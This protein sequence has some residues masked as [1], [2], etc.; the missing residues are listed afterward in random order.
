M[1]GERLGQYRIE[2]RLGVCE[3]LGGCF[4]FFGAGNRDVLATRQARGLVG[5]AGNRDRDRNLDLR[6]QRDRD[7]MHSDGLDRRVQRDLIAIDLESLLDHQR[8][9]VPR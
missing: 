8:G 4:L 1:I 7:L 5:V 3:R 6:M 2:E 9:D